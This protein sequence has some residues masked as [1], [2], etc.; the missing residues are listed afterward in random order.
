MRGEL[1]DLAGQAKSRT[2]ASSVQSLA[3]RGRARSGNTGE[4]SFPPIEA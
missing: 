2:D 3:E 4:I 1:A